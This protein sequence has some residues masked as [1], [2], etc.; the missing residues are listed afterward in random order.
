MRKDS[1][2]RDEAAFAKGKES[3]QKTHPLQEEIEFSKCPDSEIE[4]CWRYEYAREVGWLS[5][6]I[7]KLKPR[8]RTVLA[9]M[10]GYTFLACPE[11]PQQ[12]YQLISEAWRNS[13][14]LMATGFFESK[15]SECGSGPRIPR[16]IVRLGSMLKV[17]FLNFPDCKQPDLKRAEPTL[18]EIDW[19]VPDKYLMA[20]FEAFLKEF[21][22]YK[23]LTGWK[24]PVSSM[25][26]QLK[27][28]GLYRLVRACGGDISM[29]RKSGRLSAS[30]ETSLNKW[31]RA[32]ARVSALIKTAETKII[33]NLEKRDLD[34]LLNQFV[35]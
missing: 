34:S 31:Y 3:S 5:A 21:R 12:P 17:D 30:N 4:E 6:E 24:T 27:E 28:L 19:S 29:A 10:S 7:Q 16:K 1:S 25:H 18:L 35:D 2:P 9:K 15:Q 23:A 33:P 8:I 20:G 32:R 14:V 22:L 11:W 26:Q 13:A